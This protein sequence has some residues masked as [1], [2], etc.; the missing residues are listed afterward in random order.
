MCRFSKE[1]YSSSVK[2]AWIRCRIPRKSV[3]GQAEASSHELERRSVSSWW[4]GS[5]FFMCLSVEKA[6]SRVQESGWSPDL[7]EVVLG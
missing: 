3:S 2:D 1:N 6:R 4:V 5:A 7:L